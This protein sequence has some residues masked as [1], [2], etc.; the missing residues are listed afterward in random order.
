MGWGGVRGVTLRNAKKVAQNVA[1]IVAKSTIKFYFLQ[2]LQ[3][4]KLWD[5]LL[6]WYVTLDKFWCNLRHNKIA[7]QVAC[8]VRNREQ[9]AP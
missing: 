7:R 9:A 6:S 2:H 3:Q 8:L 4:Q 1:T 5:K